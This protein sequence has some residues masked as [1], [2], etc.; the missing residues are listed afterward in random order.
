VLEGPIQQPDFFQRKSPHLHPHRSFHFVPT[1]S[2]GQRVGG[3]GMRQAGKS[4][5][6]SHAPKFETKESPM[7][8]L[9]FAVHDW[10]H[11][12]TMLSGKAFIL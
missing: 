1:V 11:C 6:K 2:Q 3:K 7:S 9:R 4:Q 8:F 5:D 10:I 12:P